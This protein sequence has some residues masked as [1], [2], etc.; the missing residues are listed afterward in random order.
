MEWRYPIYFLLLLL[1]MW[2]GPYTFIF[3]ERDGPKA[4]PDTAVSDRRLRRLCFRGFI[5]ITVA[6]MLCGWLSR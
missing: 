5:A 1:M 3:F 6:V 2:L 4:P